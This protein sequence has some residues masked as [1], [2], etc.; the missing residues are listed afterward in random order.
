MAGL[1]RLERSGQLRQG[2]GVFDFGPFQ[3]HL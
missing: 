2:A 1:Y 3:L